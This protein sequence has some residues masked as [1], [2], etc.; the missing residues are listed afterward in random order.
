MRVDIGLFGGFGSFPVTLKAQA[1][2]KSEVY[3]K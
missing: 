3:W 2:G 1:T